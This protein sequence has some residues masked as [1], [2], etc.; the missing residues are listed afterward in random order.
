MFSQLFER[1]HSALVYY[2]LTQNGFC[3]KSEVKS[4]GY[5]LCDMSLIERLCTGDSQLDPVWFSCLWR[6]IILARMCS[7]NH[8]IG[9]KSKSKA[10]AG[11][12]MI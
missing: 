4:K 9:V 6:L 2:L 5:P 10:G 8:Y 3:S 1:L 12:V 11:G 7:S